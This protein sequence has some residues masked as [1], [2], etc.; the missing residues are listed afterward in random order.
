LTNSKP[1][2]RIVKLSERGKRDKKDSE[3]VKNFQKKF[4]TNGSESGIIT[5]L[6]LR[7]SE[8]HRTERKI[9]NF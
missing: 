6:L 5:E 1:S 2:A 8:V 4:L 7:K 3:K 9:K